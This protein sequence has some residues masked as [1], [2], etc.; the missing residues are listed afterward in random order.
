MNISELVLGKVKATFGRVIPSAMPKKGGDFLIKQNLSPMMGRRDAA[1]EVA[2]TL[3]QKDIFSFS[4]ENQAKLC[5]K[6]RDN[7]EN[8]IRDTRE[9]LNI[10]TSPDTVRREHNYLSLLEA[11]KTLLEVWLHL[12]IAKEQWTNNCEEVNNFYSANSLESFRH[13]EEMLNDCELALVNRLKHIFEDSQERILRYR[14][15]MTKSFSKHYLERYNKSFENY[16]V[17]YNEADTTK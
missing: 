10:L 16:F 4:D 3:S 17:V 13:D 15:Y 14:A 9:I 6:L 7:I 5:V 8:S 2:Y 12:I 11:I 1:Y